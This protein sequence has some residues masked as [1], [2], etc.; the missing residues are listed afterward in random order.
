M[1]END[2]PNITKRRKKMRRRDIPNP[3]TILQVPNT[4]QI[5]RRR[6]RESSAL[7]TINQIMKNPHA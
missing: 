5:P 3:S 4:L 7:T 2:H 1:M 6:G